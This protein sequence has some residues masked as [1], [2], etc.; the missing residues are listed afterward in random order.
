[1]GLRVC[2]ESLK[3]D[4]ADRRADTCGR[5]GSEKHPSVLHR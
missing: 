3:E 5:S 4:S 2:V 1:V